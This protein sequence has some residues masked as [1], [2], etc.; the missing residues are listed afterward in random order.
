MKFCI[1]NID[2]VV[3]V[4]Q[5]QIVIIIESSTDKDNFDR[6]KRWKI[7]CVIYL[8]SARKIVDTEVE[9]FGQQF[10]KWIN[11]IESLSNRK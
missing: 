10:L 4:H 8:I 11:V 1:E 3:I 5:T 2:F 6:E 7:R 9:H